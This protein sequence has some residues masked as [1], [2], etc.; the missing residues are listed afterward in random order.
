M[1]QQTRYRK[2]TLGLLSL[3]LLIGSAVMAAPAQA[4]ESNGPY[5]A[6]PAWDQKLPASTRFVVL[7][8]WNK[9]AVLDRETGLV[10]E[11]SPQTIVETWTVARF[12]CTNKTVGNRKGWRLPSIPELASL[13]DPTQSNPALPLLHPFNVL[14][15]NYW[16]ATSDANGPLVGAWVMNL[17]NGGGFLVSKTFVPPISLQVLCVR[18]GMNAEAY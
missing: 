10:W 2:L 18:G 12:T 5:Y 4:V 17:G 14:S 15:A 1:Q 8:D 6:N 7:L 3:G 11:R 13:I 16:S 9:E